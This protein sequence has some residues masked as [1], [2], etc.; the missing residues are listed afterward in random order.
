MQITKRD[1]VESHVVR[2][3]KTVIFWPIICYENTILQF[4]SE[5]KKTP[6]VHLCVKQSSW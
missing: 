3:P 1:A 6:T 2:N 5:I 4:V